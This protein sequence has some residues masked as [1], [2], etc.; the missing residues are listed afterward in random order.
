[1]RYG[2]DM[3]SPTKAEVT[4]LRGNQVGRTSRESILFAPIVGILAIFLNAPLIS[5]GFDAHHQGL[6]LA[7]AMGVADG[8]AIHGEVFSQY[9][10]ITSW[11]QALFLFVIPASPAL[12]LNI[13]TVV[14]IALTAVGLTLI[15]W[16]TRLNLKISSEAGL[17][18]AILWLLLSPALAAGEM[19]A[20]SSLL[21][22]LVGVTALILGLHAL[23]QTSS[24]IVSNR[25][26]FLFG[27]AIGIIPFIRL[28]VGGFLALV[29]LTWT[30]I[31]LASKWV[32]GSNVGAIILGSSTSLG[33]VLVALALTESLSQYWL[34][35]V[36]GP[37]QWAEGSNS[38][39]RMFEEIGEELAYLAPRAIP[40]AIIGI[41]LLA[42]TSLFRGRA[43]QRS[44]LTLAGAMIFGAS[45]AYA[46]QLQDTTITNGG[47]ASYSLAIPED[48]LTDGLF[49]VVFLS[50]GLAVVLGALVVRRSGETPAGEAAAATSFAVVVASSLI[51]QFW[52]TLADRQ[53]WW[54]SSIL[55]VFFI[56]L[57]Q[58]IAP[59]AMVWSFAIPVGLVAT[60]SLLSLS[61]GLQH[62]DTKSPQ[63][64]SMEGLWV[65]Q[66]TSEYIAATRDLF[67]RT[68][69][70][71]ERAF[72]S[73]IQGSDVI[74]DGEYRA[75]NKVFASWAQG[76]EVIDELSAWRGK[77]VLDSLSLSN[78]RVSS[79]PE[80]E[81]TYG[82]VTLA[83]SYTGYSG[84]LESDNPYLCVLAPEG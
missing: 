3:T 62:K 26:W 67:L 50:L 63:L 30:L 20:W 42:A 56:H 61:L 33:T 31:A 27:L 79:F 37:L 49:F 15:P 46:M 17:V 40:L 16:A 35:S 11:T 14:V 59:S 45:F 64:T 68:L 82:L 54:G 28:N 38:V 9:G 19:F 36:I 21:A 66:Q 47:G 76:P 60:V 29:G 4:P 34:Q 24:N 71:G 70:P 80:L 44:A 22:G 75:S 72:F 41:T 84:E 39:G 55:F 53:L 52:P 18:G 78:F 43:V 13:W 7:S 77:L 58:R 25:A 57:I 32:T 65:E 81:K 73:V 5:T 48:S 83:C 10:P 2:L 12:A 74:A 6:M 8:L 69:E 51:F 1:M 23:G